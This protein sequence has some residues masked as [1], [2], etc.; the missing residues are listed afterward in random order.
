[1]LLREKSDQENEHI[2]SSDAGVTDAEANG[3]GQKDGYMRNMKT[4]DASRNNEDLTLLV[5]IT[6]IPDLWVPTTFSETCMIGIIDKVSSCTPKGTPQIIADFTKVKRCKTV[7]SLLTRHHHC[8]ICGLVC[9]AKCSSMKRWL[10]T[11]FNFTEQE[12]V[13]FACASICDRLNPTNER[14]GWVNAVTFSPSDAIHARNVA[15][16]SGHPFVL[17]L[18]DND[19]SSINYEPVWTLDR[20]YKAL[21]LTAGTVLGDKM[22][23]RAYQKKM[24][25]LHPDR[26]KT[27]TIEAEAECQEV[28]K[29]YKYLTRDDKERERD[30]ADAKRKKRQRESAIAQQKHDEYSSRHMQDNFEDKINS[31][32]VCLRPFKNKIGL[33]KSEFKCQNCF[34]NVC[35]KCRI[36]KALPTFSHPVHWCVRCE[37][38]D[39]VHGTVQSL[40]MLEGVKAPENHDYLKSISVTIDLHS[41]SLLKDDALMDDSRGYALKLYWKHCDDAAEFRSET[42]VPTEAQEYVLRR[43]SHSPL[44]SYNDFCFIDTWLKKLLGRGAMMCSLPT[45]NFTLFKDKQKLIMERLSGLKVYCRYIWT[46][47]I[48]CTQLSL[49]KSTRMKKDYIDAI[50]LTRLFLGASDD[51]WTKF[52]SISKSALNFDSMSE[53]DNSSGMH[54]PQVVEYTD[55]LDNWARFVVERSF[56]VATVKLLD[57]RYVAQSKRHEMQ[58]MQTAARNARKEQWFSEGIDFNKRRDRQKMRRP[59]SAA[60]FARELAR[61]EHQSNQE[62]LVHIS[63]RTADDEEYQMDNKI[64]VSDFRSFDQFKASYLTLYQDHNAALAAQANDTALNQTDVASVPLCF[65]TKWL[66][67]TF[68]VVPT[69]SVLVGA[70]EALRM[71]QSTMK[72][73]IGRE[74]HFLIEEEKRL[75]EQKKSLEEDEGDFATMKCDIGD[76][77]ARNAKEVDELRSERAI[78]TDERN[79]RQSKEIKVLEDLEKRENLTTLRTKALES[80]QRNQERRKEAAD[81]RKL[82]QEVRKLALDQLLLVGNERQSQAIARVQVESHRRDAQYSENSILCFDRDIQNKERQACDA[83]RKDIQLHLDGAEPATQDEEAIYRTD[84]T[85]RTS[86]MESLHCN[87]ADIRIGNPRTSIENEVRHNVVEPVFD[88]L[89]ENAQSTIDATIDSLRLQVTLADRDQRFEEFIQGRRVAIDET[90]GNHRACSDEENSRLVLEKEYLAKELTRL[91]KEFKDHD[92]ANQL[93]DRLAELRRAEDESVADEV[94]I[95]G[96]KR[97]NLYEPISNAIDFIREAFSVSQMR[98]AEN[99]S[100]RS[101]CIE[102][103]ASLDS[104]VSASTERCSLLIKLEASVK[105][106]IEVVNKELDNQAA[107]PDR[108]IFFPRKKTLA[109]RDQEKVEVDSC[110]TNLATFEDSWSEINHTRDEDYSIKE[111]SKKEMLDWSTNAES[112]FLAARTPWLNYDKHEIV[113]VKG[114]DFD[115]NVHDQN[116]VTEITI[117]TTTLEEMYESLLDQFDGAETTAFDMVTT[118]DEELVE[119]LLFSK[120]KITLEHDHITE[121]RSF[122]G[123]E[124][125]QISAESDLRLAKE[126]SVADWFD[127]VKL[128]ID[129]AQNAKPKFQSLLDKAKKAVA[130]CHNH[131][132]QRSIYASSLDIPAPDGWNLSIIKGHLDTNR[133]NHNQTQKE[134]IKRKQILREVIEQRNMGIKLI[135]ANMTIRRDTLVKAERMICN[136]EVH[137]EDDWLSPNQSTA[138]ELDGLLGKVLS[139]HDRLNKDTIEKE[140][141]L[142]CAIEALEEIFGILTRLTLN[143]QANYTEAVNLESRRKESQNEFDVCVSLGSNLKM[144]AKKL[145]KELESAGSLCA[146]ESKAMQTLIKKNFRDFDRITV[147]HSS[148]SIT[149]NLNTAISCV[150]KNEQAEKSLCIQIERVE[151]AL[152]S[153]SDCTQLLNNSIEHFERA[154]KLKESLEVEANRYAEGIS[155]VKKAT[156]QINTSLIDL[157]KEQ[158]KV[159]K[160]QDAAKEALSSA[161]RWRNTAREKSYELAEKVREIEGSLER[162]KQSE[163]EERRQRELELANALEIERERAREERAREQERRR[164]D[165]DSD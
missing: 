165:S 40:I 152:K 148:S 34:L 146:T 151:V 30:A 99:K 29:A 147:G 89:S 3:A 67:D 126:Q 141:D 154:R 163:A 127:S 21:G 96:K 120:S 70:V 10:P 144:D 42:S 136:D 161:N 73:S 131:A 58:D 62:R 19:S 93:I 88:Q 94:K 113:R 98:E 101:R 135:N 112:T 125:E 104:H 17:P 84:V 52:V 71:Q 53:I 138:S 77:E 47:K 132:K 44:R 139:I 41:L 11:H 82:C 54:E 119:I 43:I 46:H 32:S 63:D 39:E 33:N 25:K 116:F 153:E 51:F 145:L 15:L 80:R 35:H 111:R 75:E 157:N 36:E 122:H 9:C 14:L 90:L 61:F 56:C 108:R 155:W 160:A 13:C 74:D 78:R 156:R 159:R 50:I 117:L 103:K 133:A 164:F 60:R 31:C 137:V 87:I 128:E 109:T 16:S 162:A 123:A 65:V 97:R 45:T 114:V 158:S 28:M 124:F 72:N 2:R 149:S 48:L 92:T 64:A 22:I 24:L 4:M 23:Q 18:C 130:W 49:A 6:M 8:R 142:K 95:G 105:C 1:M 12:R 57:E 20:A 66:L 150:K 106:R 37:K 7:F 91:T 79:A 26:C 115:G 83:I 85:Q 69:Q 86:E 143:L 134:H 27:K 68:T 55:T 5:R 107:E 129:H 81:A 121:V 76:E 38:F 100:R 59:R 140:S 118:S 110:A 102:S